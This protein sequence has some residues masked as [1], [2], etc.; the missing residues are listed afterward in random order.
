MLKGVSDPKN[1][2]SLPFTVDGSE[3]WIRNFRDYSTLDLKAD[4]ENRPV[5]VCP[6]GYLY[7]EQFTNVSKQAQDF[8]V[9]IAEPIC[10]PEFVQEYQVHLADI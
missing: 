10:R 1:W 8:L 4:H 2:G 3:Q 6:D 7:L 5:W 9:T